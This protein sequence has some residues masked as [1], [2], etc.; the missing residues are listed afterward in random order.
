LFEAA[1]DSILVSRAE[2][3]D[4]GRIVAANRAAEEALGYSNE[5]LL[6]LNVRDLLVDPSDPDI[7]SRFQ[8]MLAGERLNYE[9]EQRRK[10]GRKLMRE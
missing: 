4:T 9:V 2:G 5:E 10:D 7:D 8:R 3:P 1:S 6:A